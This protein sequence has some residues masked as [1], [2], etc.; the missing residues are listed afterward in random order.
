M[1][2][3]QVIFK[4]FSEY[5]YYAKKL[6]KEQRD[7]IFN[8]LTTKQQEKLSS[9]YHDEGWEDV[10]MRDTLDKLLDDVKKDCGTD[11]L[12]M[13]IKILKGKRQNIEKNKWTFITETFGDFDPK[14]TNYI[15]GGIE[16]EIINEQYVMLTKK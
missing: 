10:F 6:T 8:S 15:F 14:H 13:R 3:Q 12:A 2:A 9:M 7:T 16:A 11:L 4:D 1:T 5:W